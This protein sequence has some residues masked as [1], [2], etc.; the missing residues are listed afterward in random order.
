[1]RPIPLGIGWLLLF[2]VWVLA[3]PVAEA[4]P[5]NGFAISHIRY[6][7]D[8]ARDHIIGLSFRFSPADASPIDVTFVG[9]SGTIY[10]TDGHQAAC[11]TMSPGSVY[12]QVDEPIEPVTALMF[13]VAT[14]GNGDESVVVIP[15]SP[16]AGPEPAA[17]EG[18]IWGS[19]RFLNGTSPQGIQVA[20]DDNQVTEPGRDGTYRFPGLPLGNHVLKLQGDNDLLLDRI[21]VDGTR[22]DRY[23]VAVTLTARRPVAQVDFYLT[24]ILTVSSPGPKAGPVEAKGVLPRTG[25]STW[26][27]SA[28]GIFLIGLALWW[29]RQREHA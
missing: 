29:R 9:G 2:L 23:P 5:V 13:F 18:T 6:D 16:A 28:A 8:A 3:S 7:L 1:M 10:S 15:P 22:Y 25:G 27:Y 26:P 24:P 20:L 11:R 12:C 4:A 17:A 19:V 14:P 21:L